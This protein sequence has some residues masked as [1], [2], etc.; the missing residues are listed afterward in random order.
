MTRQE[1]HCPRCDR[2]LGKAPVFK[3]VRPGET[4]TLKCQTCKDW[5]DVPLRGQNTE[6]AA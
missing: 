3:E 1:L 6:R 2:Y 5:V 4:L